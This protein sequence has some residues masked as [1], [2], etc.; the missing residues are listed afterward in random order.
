MKTKNT[1]RGL[2]LLVCSSLFILSCN[3]GTNSGY[4]SNNNNPPAPASSGNN[5]TISN[6]QFG[7]NS[8]TVKAGT[9]VTW[10]NGDN[11]AHT[12]TADDGSFGSADLNNGNTYSH[13]FSSTGSFPYHC[14]HHSGMKATVVVN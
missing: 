14:I 10:T 12:V 9:T 2:L 5:I 7:T 3:K 4:G 8:L 6:M 1:S 13:L 11:V